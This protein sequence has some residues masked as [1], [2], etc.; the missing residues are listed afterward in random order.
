MIERKRELAAIGVLLGALVAADV[1]AEPPTSPPKPDTAKVDPAKGHADVKNDP[2]TKD[3]PGLAKGHDKDHP[4]LAKGH[5]KDHPGLAKGHDKDHPGLAKGELGEKAADNAAAPGIAGRRSHS[6]FRALRDELR[7]GKLKREDLD[8]RLSKLRDN[9]KER[10]DNHRAALK[11]R[12]GEHLA[13]TDAQQELSVHARRTAKLNRFLLLIQ[14][15]RKGQ[16]AEKLTARVEK[17][18][19]LENARHEKRMTQITSGGPAPIPAPPAAAVN[20]E[21]SK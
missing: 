11:A 10:Q 1:R 16:D 7:A 21:G 14:T 17:L 20:T 2:R 9:V 15:E 13:K 19:D 12:W 3:H 5:D 18:I 6:E 4:G 8:A